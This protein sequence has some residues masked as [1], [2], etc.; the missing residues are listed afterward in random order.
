MPAFHAKYRKFSSFLEHYSLVGSSHEDP[1][2]DLPASSCGDALDPGEQSMTFE[3]VWQLLL[4]VP[5]VLWM[6]LT[7]Y[8]GGATD[9]FAVN[10][11]GTL[12]LLA[13]CFPGLAPRKSGL[14]AETLAQALTGLS[15]KDLRQGRGRILVIETM[16]GRSNKRKR[17][18][19]TT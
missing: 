1:T 10:V 19:L 15:E 8:R 11:F 9:R 6:M 7:S 17:S 13:S 5:L 14:A 16:P 4:V 3:C 2:I 18:D 12:L